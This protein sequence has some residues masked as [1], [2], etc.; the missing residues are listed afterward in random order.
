[1]DDYL[2]LYACQDLRGPMLISEV[3]RESE[4]RIEID[5]T[6]ANLHSSNSSPSSSPR[7]TPERLL[8]V[9]VVLS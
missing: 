2:M 6:D 4:G 5:T 3:M 1:M 8:W 7:F 9:P